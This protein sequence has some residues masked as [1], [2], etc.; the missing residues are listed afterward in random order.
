MFVFDGGS[1]HTA[2]D[3]FVLPADELS[4]ARFVPSTVLEAHLPAVMVNRLLAAI[5]ASH[6]THIRYLER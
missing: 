4:E 3:Q 5:D 2:A 6:D 1:T